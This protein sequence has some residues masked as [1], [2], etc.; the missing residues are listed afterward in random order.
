MSNRRKRWSRSTGA[1]GYTV[2]VQ[3]KDVGDNL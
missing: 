1:R 2:R 3:E